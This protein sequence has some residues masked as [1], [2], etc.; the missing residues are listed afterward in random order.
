MVMYPHF[1][2]AANLRVIEKL[3]T[4]GVNFE[5]RVGVSSSE[6]AG[7]IFVLTGTLSS[8]GRSEAK[9]LIESYGGRVASGVSNSTNYLISSGEN[10]TKQRKA[11]ELGIKILSESEFLEMLKSASQNSLGNL[12]ESAQDKQSPKDNGGKDSQMTFGF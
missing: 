8:M 12:S 9:R 5:V 4:F 2:S 3:R 1:K 7:K 10:S 11:L 6:F